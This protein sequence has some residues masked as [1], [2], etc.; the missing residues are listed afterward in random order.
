LELKDDE[1]LLL[2]TIEGS[3]DFQAVVQKVYNYIVEAEMMAAAIHSRIV[4]LSD[5]QKRVAHNGEVGRALLHTLL[6]EAGVKKIDVRNYTVSGDEDSL[7]IR[8]D[9]TP[10]S[11][12]AR[13]VGVVPG[14]PA[15]GLQAI[16]AG[17]HQGTVKRTR[18]VKGPSHCARPCGMPEDAFADRIRGAV[19]HH[20]SA[21]SRDT[22]RGGITHHSSAD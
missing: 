9:K 18:G 3:T 20:G 11:L 14:D 6:T 10:N 16:I 13:E 4:K 5:R 12:G 17:I 7:L 19:I 22:R 21:G 2:D 1:Q 15:M 8:S